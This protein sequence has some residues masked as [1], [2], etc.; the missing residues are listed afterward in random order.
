MYMKTERSGGSER[1]GAEAAGDADAILSSQGKANAPPA[2]C[3]TVLREIRLDMIR[4]FLM[5][6]IR[7]RTRSHECEL[8]THECVRHEFLDYY[9][10]HM[11]LDGS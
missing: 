9:W 7:I 6:E 11:L 1:V 3:K 10:D 2:P 4:S 8:G 5:L